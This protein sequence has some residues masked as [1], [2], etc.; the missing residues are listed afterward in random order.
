MAAAFP[1]MSRTFIFYALGEMNA[2]DWWVNAV[3]ALYE[4]NYHY[5]LWQ[6]VRYEGFEFY[7]GVKQ[8]CPLSAIL[9]VYIFDMCIKCLV[10]VLRDNENLVC[11]VAD[12]VGS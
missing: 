12:D 3:K 10:S 1:S 6:G 9:F 2:P 5:I 4:A 8:G 11:A 7:R